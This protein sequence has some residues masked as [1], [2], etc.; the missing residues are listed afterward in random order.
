MAN[1]MRDKPLD[2]IRELRE[3]KRIRRELIMLT[4]SW[5]VFQ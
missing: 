3:S 2:A 5:K 1:K 4:L